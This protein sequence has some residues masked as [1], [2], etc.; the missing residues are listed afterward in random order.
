MNLN[1]VS[2][3]KVLLRLRNV[4]LFVSFPLAFLVLQQSGVYSIH[5]AYK[6]ERICHLVL[7][8]KTKNNK[9]RNQTNQTKQQQH[10]KQPPL[11]PTTQ[12]CGSLVQSRIY[13]KIT[14]LSGLNVCNTLHTMV[15][16]VYIFQLYQEYL[17]YDILLSLEIPN[18]VTS[19]EICTYS[20]VH[21]RTHL[22]CT[23]LTV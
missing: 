3:D 20:D 22:S 9:K 15:I 2:I 8:R 19:F 23:A 10:Q 14:S 12:K 7:F 17:T 11:P 16:V 4:H 1:T 13:R 18:H 5:L 6:D 21:Q